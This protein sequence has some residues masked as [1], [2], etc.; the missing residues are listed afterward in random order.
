LS[1]GRNDIRI[2]LTNTVGDKT[3]TLVLNHEG[4]GDLDKRGTLYI[5]AIGVDKYPGLGDTCG[6]SS[7][8]C[9]LHFAVADALAW[10]DAAE[11]RLGPGHGKVV[12]QALVNGVGDKD[13][14]TASN[15]T[16]AIDGL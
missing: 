3:E 16:D 13:A 9:D 10:A 15:I 6:N 7:H 4:D 2:T 14:P 5:L 12:K 1:K 8:T 11:R